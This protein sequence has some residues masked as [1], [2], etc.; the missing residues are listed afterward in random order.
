MFGA[1]R[2][3]DAI[4]ILL[5][6]VAIYA[7]LRF[8]RSTR[9]VGILRGLFTVTLGV[10]LLIGVLDKFVFAQVGGLGSIS[11]ILS[12]VIPFFAVIVVIL[13]QEE[14]RQGI[15]RFGQ[16]G[17][18]RFSPAGETPGELAKVATSARRLANQR[19]GA[20]IAIERQISLKPFS[21]G[22]EKLDLP[23]TSI[24]LETIFFPG[25]P[26]HDGGVVLRGSNIAAASCIFPLTTNPEIQRRMGTRHRAAIGLTEVTDAVVVVIS[27]ETG[28]ISL[29]ADGELHKPIPPDQLERRMQ[30][31][32]KTESKLV[33]KSK[34]ED[35]GGDAAEGHAPTED[36]ALEV[37]A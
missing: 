28:E 2:I 36:T 4:E 15:S 10:A 23:I 35:E 12:K 9:G 8:I 3:A 6:T 5:L 24:L 7:V 13:F 33:R 27:E 25:G 11:L 26:M 14:L 32:L 18:F 20:L 34:A 30:E 16:G 17:L 22:A 31:L 37:E 21:Q 29:A 1:H 19:I